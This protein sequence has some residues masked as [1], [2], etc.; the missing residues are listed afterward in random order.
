ML[1]YDGTLVLQFLHRPKVWLSLPEKGNE[2]PII[3]L[4]L[5]VGSWTRSRVCV[6][7]SGYHMETA[8][9]SPTAH[10]LGHSQS[11]DI[12]KSTVAL[13]FPSTSGD[14]MRGPPPR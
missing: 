12:S 14:L 7:E 5:I 2:L 9:V 6:L 13:G 3:A 4:K 1:D 8:S 10:L 11:F